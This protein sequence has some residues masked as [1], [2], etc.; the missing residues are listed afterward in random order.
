LK[1]SH[2]HDFLIVIIIDGLG[3]NMS[4]VEY[5]T[6]LRYRLMIPLFSIDKVCHVCL[7][8]CMD[9]FREHA[10]HNYKELIGFKYTHGFT[11]DVLFDIFRQV[12]VSVKRETPVNFL[13]DSLDRRSTLRHEDLMACVVF[14]S[15]EYLSLFKYTT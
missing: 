4:L 7:K 1:A 6:I 13:T 11:R 2:A 3:Q 12:E 15:T 5:C 10:V 9:T 14:R 8:V